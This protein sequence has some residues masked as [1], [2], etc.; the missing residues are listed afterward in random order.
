M[1]V[2]VFCFVPKKQSTN[3]QYKVCF[4]F[5]APLAPFAGSFENIESTSLVYTWR[6]VEGTSVVRVYD[7]I[8]N[9]FSETISISIC[10][11]CIYISNYLVNKQVF[12]A[13]FCLCCVD[14][15]NLILTKTLKR[16]KL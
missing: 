9:Y 14:A 10:N 11:K 2:R 15:E 12:N 7:Q 5:A 4:I 8:M 16:C 3:A 1:C 6:A 13:F